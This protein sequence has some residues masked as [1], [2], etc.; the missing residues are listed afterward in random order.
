MDKLLSVI[1]VAYKHADILEK[2]LESLIHYNDIGDCL[3][4]IVS[5]NSPDDNIKDMVN[6]K[7]GQVKYLRNDNVGFGKGNNRGVEISTS[8]LL[9]FLNPD[10]IFIEPV[11]SFALNKFKDSNLTMFGVKLLSINRKSNTSFAYIDCFSIKKQIIGKLANKLN[12]FDSE[13]MSILGADI[14]IRKSVFDMAGRFDENIFMYFEENDLTKRVK[15]IAP[16]GKI[17]FFKEKS[18]IHLEGGTQDNNIDIDS[19]VQTRIKTMYYYADKWNIEK[20][21][22]LVNCIKRFYILAV[23]SLFKLDLRMY[24][25]NIAIAKEYKKLLKRERN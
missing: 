6:K 14:F 4:I 19:Y 5:D 7:F 3:E 15:K 17:G 25:M 24:R 23:I 18:I 9:L 8:N 2:C 10:T 13:N 12:F 20:S 16:N 21:V 22:L 1:I 11:F